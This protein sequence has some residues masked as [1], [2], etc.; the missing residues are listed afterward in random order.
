MNRLCTLFA[1]LL[2]FAGVQAAAPDAPAPAAGR[3][4]SVGLHDYAKKCPICKGRG[5]LA[6]RPP[7][8]GQHAGAIEHKGHWD[9][10]L[11]CPICSGRGKIRAYRTF[12]K[13]PG[14]PDVVEPCRRCG[15]AGCESCRKCKGALVVKCPNHCKD[16]WIVTNVKQ[17][18]GHAA[19]LPPNVAPC[20]ECKGVGKISC[21]DC[22]GRGGIP[23][24][25]C[26]GLGR[27]PPKNRSETR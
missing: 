1:F 12:V 8:H 27:T 11:V 24:R 2:L 7:D 5:K 4:P 18:P 19:R 15:F 21:V 13:A 16:G 23:C 20:P 25:Q 10:K 9:V 17:P 6:L 14:G 26:N 3:P 22:E